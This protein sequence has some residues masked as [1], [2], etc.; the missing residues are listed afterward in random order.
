[1]EGQVELS[2]GGAD[3]HIGTASPLGGYRSGTKRLECLADFVRF[4]HVLQAHQNALKS[5][6]YRKYR[7]R[8]VKDSP[9][10]QE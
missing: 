10:L 9:E 6:G 8:E 3:H 2:K 4:C 1:M 5:L 7:G